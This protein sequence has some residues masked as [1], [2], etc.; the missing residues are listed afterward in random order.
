MC[1]HKRWTRTECCRLAAVA[2]T[3]EPEYGPD[4]IQPVG[5][6]VDEPA[7]TELTKKDLKWVTLDYTNVETQTFYLFTDAGHKG[8]LQVIYNNIA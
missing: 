7:Y 3:Q 2:G 1:L 4:A 8:F 6:K 5:K